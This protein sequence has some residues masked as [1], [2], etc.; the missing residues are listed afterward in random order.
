VNSALGSGV[1]FGESICEW[2][3]VELTGVKGCKEVPE[4]CGQRD[5]AP[6]SSFAMERSSEH[7]GR[8]QWR[9]CLY[10]EVRQAAAKGQAVNALCQMTG[11]SRAGYYRWGLPAYHS[12]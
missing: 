4:P 12:G 3:A 10:E 6:V 5:F 7:A 11:L 1:V 8:R 9:G 2:F